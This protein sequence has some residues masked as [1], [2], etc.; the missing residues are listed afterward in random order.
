MSA[1]STPMYSKNRLGRPAPH[2]L[3]SSPRL[4]TAPLGIALPAAELLRELVFLHALIHYHRQVA[5]DGV[6]GRH[7]LLRRRVDHV[8]QFGKYDFLRRHRRQ[9]VDSLDVDH[10]AFHQAGLE[11][12]SE[13]HT[14]ELQ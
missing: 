7:Q 1:I 10:P 14:S 3:G 4:I 13:E 11:G 9:L 2:S 6:D 8:E 12:R 5:A